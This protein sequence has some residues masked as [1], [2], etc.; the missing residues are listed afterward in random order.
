MKTNKL[1]VAAILLAA[2]GIAMAVDAPP[3]GKTREQVRAELAQARASG[4]YDALTMLYVDPFPIDKRRAT[5]TDRTP[6][7]KPQQ[8]R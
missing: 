7:D 3:T 8:P 2:A 1:S 4:E 5:Q 6:A